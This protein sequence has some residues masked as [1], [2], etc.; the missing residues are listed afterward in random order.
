L[1]IPRAGWKL[2]TSFTSIVGSPYLLADG[3]GK[4]VA[5]VA[6]GTVRIPSGPAPASGSARKDWVARWNA[7]GTGGLASSN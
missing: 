4:A 7:R 5:V 1:A 2:D 3:L 6:D